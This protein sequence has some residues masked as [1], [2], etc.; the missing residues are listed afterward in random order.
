MD[1]FV[2]QKVWCISQWTVLWN[3]LQRGSLS[4]GYHAVYN[5]HLTT[6]NVSIVPALYNL[7][8]PFFIFP[9]SILPPFHFCFRFILPPVFV[10][11]DTSSCWGICTEYPKRKYPCPA[12]L[13]RWGNGNGWVLWLLQPRRGSR[14]VVSSIGPN[15]RYYACNFHKRADENQGECAHESVES[16]NVCKLFRSCSSGDGDR[17]C[18]PGATMSVS[19]KIKMAQI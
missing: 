19:F 18:L 9:S 1:L 3:L 13:F 14:R 10:Y 12:C 11:N 8:F 6:F 17:T 16:H 4:L 15:I 5:T 7:I 2:I